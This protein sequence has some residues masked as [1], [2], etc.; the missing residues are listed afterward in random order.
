MK[1]SEPA[2]FS[3]RQYK[4]GQERI[5]HAQL[6]HLTIRD[7]AT[8][9]VQHMSGLVYAKTARKLL[10][11]FVFA[12]KDEKQLELNLEVGDG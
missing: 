3:R 6:A 7:P 9:E 8:H 10:K 1:W 12:G 5:D 2:S 4:E 11:A